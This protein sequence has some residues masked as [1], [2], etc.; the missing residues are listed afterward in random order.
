MRTLI[1]ILSRNLIRLLWTFLAVA[2]VTLLLSWYAHTHRPD[3]R[4]GRMADG[5]VVFC[6]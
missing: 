1:P 5:S 6:E 2:L 3:D 4:C